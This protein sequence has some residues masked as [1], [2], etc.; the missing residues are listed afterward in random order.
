MFAV[1]EDEILE[2][3]TQGLAPKRLAPVYEQA[4]YL[5]ASLSTSGGVCSS[6]NPYAGPYHHA[7]K[8][9]QGLS[10]GAHIFQPSVGTSSSSTS[11][12]PLI[13]IPL[14]ITPRSREAPTGTL[15]KRVV[16]SSWWPQ[17]ENLCR[18]APAYIPP[19]EDRKHLMPKHPATDYPRI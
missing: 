3:L 11:E 10:I 9:A 7:T 5:P 12:C 16:S 1:E 15:P 17:P 8:T 18:I 14:M 4:P 13:K 19:S 6:L 2:L